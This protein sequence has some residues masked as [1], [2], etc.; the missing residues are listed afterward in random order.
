MAQEI[1]QNLLRFI[2]GYATQNGIRL[3][4]VR[5][6]KFLYLADLYYARAHSG[7]TLTGFPWAFIHYGPYC[8]E[9]F[10]AIQYSVAQGIIAM[11]ALESKFDE[12]KDYYIFFCFDRVAVEESDDKLPFEVTAA[13]KTAI[14]EFGDDTPYLLD[15]VYF[16]TEPMREAQKGDILDFTK[17]QRP[18]P[19]KPIDLKEIPQKKIELARSYVKALGEKFALNRIKS[20]QEK[21]E[22]KKLK[23]AIYYRAIEI[24]DEEDL[25]VGLKGTARIEP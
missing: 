5:L 4:T 6:V 21:S 12:E 15:H 16:E 7:K 18:I 23:D 20:E 8:S 10:E 19:S 9:A 1:V 13:L 22:S 11:E 14:R 2:V 25:E 24:M 3:T 17:A